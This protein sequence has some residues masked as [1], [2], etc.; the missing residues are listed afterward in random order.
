MVVM[1]WQLDLMI[2]E[3][4]SNRNDSMILRLAANTS[5]SH[6]HL[7]SSETYALRSLTTYSSLQSMKL[8][9]FDRKT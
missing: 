5:C 6:R 4:F 3:V 2:S 1:G 9:A 8:E 7:S